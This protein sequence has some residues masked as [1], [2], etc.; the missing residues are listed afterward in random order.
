VCRSRWGKD[1]FEERCL[2]QWPLSA[3]AARADI[4][5]DNSSDMATLRC[6]VEALFRQLILW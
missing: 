5:I 1:D 6:N 3:K 2:R 4:V